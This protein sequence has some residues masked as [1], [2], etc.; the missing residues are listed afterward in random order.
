MTNGYL[1]IHLFNAYLLVNNG[2]EANTQVSHGNVR[3]LDITFITFCIMYEF[4][5]F[6]MS[7]SLVIK[8]SLSQV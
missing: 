2:L 8:V 6:S 3:Y 4:M 1:F 7:F 5:I